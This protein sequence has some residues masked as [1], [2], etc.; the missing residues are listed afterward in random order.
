MNDRQYVVGLLG[1]NSVVDHRSRKSINFVS[2]SVLCL[3]I[4]GTSFKVPMSSFDAQ[5]KFFVY[6][7]IHSP[8]RAC[9]DMYFVYIG[10][11][12]WRVKTTENEKKSSMHLVLFVVIYFTWLHVPESYESYWLVQ[13]FQEVQDQKRR[14]IV[15]TAGASFPGTQW[16]TFGRFQVVQVD[17]GAVETVYHLQCSSQLHWKLHVLAAL[18]AAMTCQCLQISLPPFNRKAKIPQR[19]LIHVHCVRKKSKPLN[20]FS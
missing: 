8:M 5:Y 18:Y 2:V 7:L 6:S 20:M 16:A 1:Y 14:R 9:L 19:R 17:A 11:V 10:T 15:E 13:E 12:K 3:H 4:L